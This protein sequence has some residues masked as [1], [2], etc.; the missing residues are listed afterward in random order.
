MA[1]GVGG[2][3]CRWRVVYVVSGVCG[4]WRVVYVGSGVCGAVVSGEWC[5]RCMWCACAC[6]WWLVSE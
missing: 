1:S 2:E 3:W 4:E 5:M 6:A